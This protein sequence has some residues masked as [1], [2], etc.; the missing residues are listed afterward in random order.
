MDLAT[1]Q[2]PQRRFVVSYRCRVVRT[3]PDRSGRRY[4]V[5]RT[6]PDRSGRRY[7]VVRTTPD[8]SDRTYCVGHHHRHCRPPTAD[9]R[10]PTADRRPPTA[11]R[12]PPTADDPY[13]MTI[14][15][16]VATDL[17]GRT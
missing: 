15:A 4:G 5:V 6:T 10:P 16:S 1:N 11:D 13:Q 7:G 8:A 9:R 12:R 17:C 14:V 2:N 3:A